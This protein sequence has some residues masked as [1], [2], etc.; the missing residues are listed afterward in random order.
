MAHDDDQT[1]LSRRQIV[2]TAALGA[3]GVAGSIGLTKTIE[4]TPAAAQPRPA[5]GKAEVAPGQLDDY[6][7]FFSSGQT[8]ELRI[9][10]MPSMRELMRVPVFNRCSATGWG[11]TNESRKIMTEGL[12]PE[13]RERLKDRLG[14]WMNG[15]CHH[16][17]MSFTNGTYDGRYV[18]INDKAN[19]RL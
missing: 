9:V 4:T 2:G 15:D 3:A 13:T 11:Q 8:G 19:T 17:H 5:P 10:G 12:L 6:Y 7:V 18:F 1:K 16:P 14:I